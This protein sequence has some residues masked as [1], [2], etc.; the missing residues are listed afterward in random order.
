MEWLSTNIRGLGEM[1]G[2]M[3]W[4]A[5]RRIV[6]VMAFFVA[7]ALSH[8]ERAEAQNDHL[9]IPWKRI[10]PIEMRGPFVSVYDCG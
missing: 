5:A 7:V 2:L 6:L 3:G 9:I 4:I 8:P 10:G 1:H